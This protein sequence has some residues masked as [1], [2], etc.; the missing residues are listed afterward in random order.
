MFHLTGS[1]NGTNCD[2]A[3]RRDFLK[4]GALGLGGFMLPDLLRARAAA[5]AQGTA[6]TQ[7][8]RRLALARRRPV[9][10]RNLRSQAGRARR[11]P[12][13]RRPRADLSARRPVRRR[14]SEA[15]PERRQAGRG[16]F[17]RPQQQRPRRRHPL[18][19]DRLQLPARPTT[20]AVRTS[21]ASAPSSRASAAPTTPPPACR[22]TSAPAASSATAPPGSAPP[23]PRSTWAATPATT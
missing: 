16:A 11:V 8:L 17:L 13:H 1:R 6:H 5:A 9:A 10:H 21:P 14:L 4:I 15:G 3:S 20:A 2:G 18:G 23:T 12:Q 22:P 7:H 19:D